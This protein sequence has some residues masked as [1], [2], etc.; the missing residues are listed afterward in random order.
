MAFKN[1]N[2]NYLKIDR[3]IVDINT[4]YSFAII[5]YKIYEN[6]NLR[7]NGL[8][9]FDNTINERFDTQNFIFSQDDNKSSK[10]N[11]L[12]GAYLTLKSNGFENWI[13][14]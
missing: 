8:G 13:D 14:A 2:D 6:E 9:Q 10:D 12:T 11:L 4:N 5:E 3:I 1:T 7:I